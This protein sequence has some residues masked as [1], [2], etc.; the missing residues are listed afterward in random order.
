MGVKNILEDLIRKCFASQYF[1]TGDG[2]AQEVGRNIRM[3]VK[4]ETGEQTRDGCKGFSAVCN[5]Y[6]VETIAW[7]GSK[8]G[9]EN[10]AGWKWIRDVC[11][12]SAVDKNLFWQSVK[13]FTIFDCRRGDQLSNV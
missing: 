5:G 6:E 3:P 2:L 8:S 11:Y 4:F 10:L 7:H 12:R 9:A 13:K 1:K